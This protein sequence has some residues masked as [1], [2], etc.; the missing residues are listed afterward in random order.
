VSIETELKLSFSANQL[1]ILLEH[2]LISGACKRHKLFNVYYDTPELSLMKSG[3]AVRE[4]KILRKTLLTVKLA[5]PSLGGMHRR[6]EWEAPTI[7]GQFDFQ[8]LIDDPV[9][10]EKMTM[11]APQLVPIFTTEFVRRTWEVEFRGAKIEVAIDQGKIVTKRIDGLLYQEEICEVELE[12]LEGNPVNLFGL[13]RVLS[14]R[15]RL[16]PSSRSKAEV[17]YRLYQNIVISPVKPANLEINP[18]ADPLDTFQHICFECLHHLQLNDVGILLD[19][20]DEYIHQARVAMR[21]IR[22]AIKLFAPV[23]PMTFVGH[24]NNIWRDLA[25][26]LGDARNWDVFCDELL[27]LIKQTFGNHP[28]ILELEKFAIAERL[29]GHQ[30]AIATFGNRNYSVKVI[31]FAEAVM[32][33]K[34]HPEIK[35]RQ[36][37]ILESQSTSEPIVPENTEQFSSRL[38]KRRHRRFQRELT[39]PTRTLEESH[40]LRL[41]L[42]KLRYSFEFFVQLFPKKNMTRYTKTLSRA[43]EL[44]GQMNDLATAEI[45]LSKRNLNQVDVATA[46]IIGRQ[47]GYLSMMPKVIAGLNELKAPWQK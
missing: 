43:Q 16:H 4:R 20:D 2:P 38:L 9:L 41:Y 5:S 22:S 40:Q 1:P 32:S 44:L 23:L 24:W 10:A 29:A 18:Q 33:L 27:P 3:A 30:S 42:K 31:S 35:N 7:P 26:A 37:M 21:R 6:L 34:N 15:V 8:T 11:L 19:N 17:G 14:R 39:V 36:K 13:A 25:N 46:W 12:L 28:D 47:S 45:L